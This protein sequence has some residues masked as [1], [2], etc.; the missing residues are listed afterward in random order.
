MDHAHHPRHSRADF[1]AIETVMPAS[2][3]ENTTVDETVSQ[4]WA[5]FDFD[6]TLTRRDTLVP[7]LRQVLGVRRLTTVMTLEAPGLI[8]YAAGVIPNNQAKVRLLRRALGGMCKEALEAEGNCFAE[9]GVPPLLRPVMLRRLLRHQKL[10]HVCVLVTAS[11]TLYTKPWAESFG[12][13]HVIGSKLAFDEQRKATG[14]LIGGNCYGPEKEKRLRTL[15]PPKVRLY[16]YGDSRGDQEMLT[17]ADHGWRLG[18]EN[19]Y[20]ETLPTI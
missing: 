11:L 5:A 17:M 18:R 15:L 7:F 9:Q 12:F 10:G 4:A 6:G 13:A 2:I 3:T 1:Q 19:K 14:A 8:A 20:G 16:A